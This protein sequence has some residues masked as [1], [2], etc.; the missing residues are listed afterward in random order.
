M[1]DPFPMEPER[2]MRGSFKASLQ[3]LGQP[4]DVQLSCY[5]DGCHKVD[6]L[7]IDYGE[8]WRRYK[9]RFA[10]ELTAEQYAAAEAVDDYLGQISGP[11]NAKLWSERALLVRPEWQEARRLAQVALAAFG[12]PQEVPDKYWL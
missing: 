11:A 6:E 4:G 10:S 3:V 8:S 12:W 1:E 7:A 9:Q 2:W 5:P